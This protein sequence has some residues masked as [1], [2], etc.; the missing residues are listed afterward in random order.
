MKFCSCL[1]VFLT[2]MASVAQ[3]LPVLQK[4]AAPKVQLTG[5][6]GSTK[7][8][9]W[10]VAA[11]PDD[12]NSSKYVYSSVSRPTVIENLPQ[13]L[14]QTDS[15]QVQITAVPN[16][17][18]YYVLKTMPLIEPVPVEVTAGTAGSETYYYW[19]AVMNGF[20]LSETYG[21]Y[22][23]EN[24]RSP[25][26]NTITWQPVPGASGYAV[27]RTKTAQP[28]Y[29]RAYHC[30][31][32]KYKETSFTDIDKANWY[33]GGLPA[34]PLNQ[35]PVGEGLF[36]VGIS[37][38]GSSVTDQGQ[39][40]DYFIAP[41]INETELKPIMSN[42]DDLVD[43]RKAAGV[44][45]RS[46]LKTPNL[47]QQN[48]SG[49]HAS[50]LR[51]DMNAEAG[52]HSEY[53]DIPGSRGGWKSWTEVLNLNMSSK[54]A[55]Q[56]TLLRGNLYAYGS[57]DVIWNHADIYNYGV[58]DDSGD[59]G[60]SSYRGA[61]TRGLNIKD[62]TL[63]SDMSI[64]STV[65]H[66]GSVGG[67]FGTGRVVVNLTQQ[68]NAGRIVRVDNVTAKGKD[69]T[70]TPAMEGYWISFDVDTTSG[71]RQWYFVKKVIDAQTLTFRAKTYW[72]DAANLGYS[73]Y[74]YDPAVER[75]HPN[76]DWRRIEVS[77]QAAAREGDYILAPG[78]RIGTPT[79]MRGGN[80]HVE[81]LREPWNVNDQIR[82]VAG[83]NIYLNMAKY[84][85]H[86]N[87][88]PQDDVRGG[89]TVENLTPQVANGPG[90]QVGF[91]GGNNWQTGIQIVM[92]PDGI[93]SGIVIE[94]SKNH[95]LAPD[96]PPS[97]Q[98]EAIRVPTG[99]PGLRGFRVSPWIQFEKKN[100]DIS[101][102][103]Q[104][105]SYGSK[106]L[107]SFQ[108]HLVESNVP[109]VAN[110]GILVEDK[111]EVKDELH[112]SAKTRGKAVFTVDGSQTSFVVKFERR[113]SDT[114]FVLIST[115]QF[116]ASRLIRVSNTGFTV[117]FE[118][119]PATGVDAV[120]IYWMIQL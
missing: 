97:T 30:I 28:P 95:I 21:S 16:A 31:A 3:A 75:R 50:V 22:A 35:T 100:G 96:A 109:I 63:L 46:N 56:H 117:E 58:N 76:F 9:Y 116:A 118:K 105:R 112:G 69:T 101:A 71:F 37:N 90:V 89:V 119:A 94:P 83:P 10:I 114:P 103:M 54:V 85:L 27:Y 53:Y 115:N 78:T 111:L 12:V 44:A 106:P 86:G 108:E 48:F 24:T 4:P 66:V 99:M 88:L 62:F 82:V 32:L 11:V 65:L 1:I 87:L 91:P 13:V 79:Q 47:A 7:A 51:L 81:P 18:R 107:V 49:A 8:C 33:V 36:L 120:V 55:S 40:L 5:Q 19:I 84:L 61:V 14:S 113:I 6:T 110:K 59:E 15:A 74:I 72:T 20:R 52:G 34:T 42:R 2:L 102:A 43:V 38:D 77:R 41:N 45:V 25:K 60:T 92:A 64:G 68:Y 70:W 17:T 73:R 39:K 29:G 80:L 93:G 23:V 104:V 57:G 26:G 98:F 67:Q